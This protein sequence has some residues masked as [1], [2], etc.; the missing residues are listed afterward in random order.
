MEG[1]EARYHASR[2]IHSSPSDVQMTGTFA[3][4]S[5]GHCN[6]DNG[7]DLPNDTE[8]VAGDPRETMDVRHRL[9]VLLVLGLKGA[10]VVAVNVS[11]YQQVTEEPETRG[12]GN[13]QCQDEEIA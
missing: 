2:P 9:L 4:A 6:D 10:E 5:E 11:F 7:G 8:Q 12:A 1:Y 13:V 3:P